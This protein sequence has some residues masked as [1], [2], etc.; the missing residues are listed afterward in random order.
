MQQGQEGTAS[1]AP[2]MLEVVAAWARAA[3]ICLLGAVSH[4]ESAIFNFCRQLLESTPANHWRM[5]LFSALATSSLLRGPLLR[6]Y[7]STSDH[8]RRLVSILANAKFSSP[9][10]GPQHALNSCGE[11]LKSVVASIK[12]TY[13]LRYVY[14]WHAMAGFW[15]GLGLRDPD[16][17]K[18]QPRLVLPTPTPGMLATDPAVAWVQPVV[19]GVGLPADP[20]VLHQ[21]MHQYLAACGVDGVKVDVQS[22]IGLLGSALGGGPATAAAY[23]ASLEASTRRHFPGNH[24]INCMCHST[25]DMYRMEDTNLARVSDDFYPANPASH[26]TH[27]ANC[28][29]NTLFMGELVI[30]DWDMFH[31]QHIK[32]LL[33]ATA[34]AIS[35]GPVYV[36]DR[37]G[38]HDFELL[39]RLVLPD[40]SVLR[41]CLPG[42]PIADCLFSNVSQDGITALK[43][44]N[45]N[46]Y[47]GVVAVFNVQG[48]SFSRQLRR[49]HTHDQ[50]PE[51]LTATVAAA[52]VPVLAE[53]GAELFAA[54]TD[55]TQELALLGAHDS[56]S[57][58]VQGGGGSD[59]VTMSPVADAGGVLLAPIGLVGMLNAGGAVLSCSLSGGHSDDGF[60]VQPA[61]ALLELRGTGTILCYASHKPCSV[62]VKGKEVDFRY[63]EAKAAL[64]FEL[65][66]GEAASAAKTVTI[67]F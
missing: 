16:M 52:D 25:E 7:A 63:D 57:I 32:A 4:T 27:I 48:S 43:V 17:A 36:S 18:Y 8:S 62:T 47:C 50:Q 65:P 5:H 11:D 46:A 45:A 20:A 38:R 42:R 14:C 59:V 2:G 56:L 58:A 19:S 6:Y 26:T 53:S 10:A 9:G 24:L 23:H 66:A 30:P 15:G 3:Y 12:E 37:P 60:E 22:T 29:F 44:W 1:K 64:R 49:F 67:Q 34:R 61:R 39:R 51:A 41:C 13:G 21:D 28:A 35:G 31:S 40:G 33:H 54:Y 55:S